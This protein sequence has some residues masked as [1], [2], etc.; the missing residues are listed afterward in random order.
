MRQSSVLWAE[1]GSG[2]TALMEAVVIDWLRSLATINAVAEPM[3]RS[4]AEVDRIQQ[5]AVARGLARRKP[6]ALRRLGIDE[7]AFQRRHE[8]VTVLTNHDGK[9]V[10]HVADK[11]QRDGADAFFAAQRPEDLASIES[12]TMGMWKSCITSVRQHVPDADP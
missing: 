10:V 9:T 8:Y 2:F 12:V 4:W 5:R 7:T 1:L 11:R 3:R 6:E